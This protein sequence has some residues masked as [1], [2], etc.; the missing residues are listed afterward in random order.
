MTVGANT[1]FET[2]NLNDWRVV[3]AYSNP[4][5]PSIVNFG[6]DSGRSLQLSHNGGSYSSVY[7]YQGIPASAANK[8]FRVEFSTMYTYNNGKNSAR[9]FQTFTWTNHLQAVVSCP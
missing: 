6:D 8:W 2:N 7:L 4:M 3:Q 9:C 5:T 1:G